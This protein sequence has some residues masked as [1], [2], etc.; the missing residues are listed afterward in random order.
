MPEYAGEIELAENFVK[1]SHRVPASI[2]RVA[3]FTMTHV[4]CDGWRVEPNRAYRA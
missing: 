2:K 1:F 4:D 3:S